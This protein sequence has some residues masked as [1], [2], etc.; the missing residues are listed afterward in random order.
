FSFKDSKIDSDITKFTNI[1]K[2][3][4]NEI[5]ELLSEIGNYTESDYFTSLIESL[6]SL[7]ESNNYND[8]KLNLD[9]KMQNLPRGNDDLSKESKT[10]IS[11]IIK[12]LNEICI[13]NDISDIKTKIMK[14]KNYV[15]AII[16]IIKEL[17]KRINKFK[18]ENDLY[19]FIDISNIS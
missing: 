15:E 1:I 18:Y 6:N 2:T 17:D 13:N 9:K 5:D 19:E 4:I 3:K 8:I 11:D 10:R 12:E 16:S 14:T 7:I